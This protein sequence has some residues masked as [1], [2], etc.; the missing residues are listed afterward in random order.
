MSALQERL[1]VVLA[2]IDPPWTLSGGGALAGF[3]SAHRE[4]RDLDLFWQRRR[5]LGDV[6]AKV[7]RRLEDEGLEA[8]ALQTQEAFCRLAVRD[9][10]TTVTIAPTGLTFDAVGDVQAL[11]VTVLDVDGV[12]MTGQTVAWGRSSGAIASVCSSGSVT[13]TGSGTARIRATTA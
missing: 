9:G 12:E 8:K 7:V 2:G 4:T 10:A 13:S 6:V 11:T 1:L 5:D 3:Y